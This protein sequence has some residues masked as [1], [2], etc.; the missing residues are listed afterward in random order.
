MRRVFGSALALAL[1]GCATAQFHSV[2]EINSVG[3]ECGVALG[4]LFQDESEKRLLFLMRP[5]ATREQRACIAK[6]ARANHLKP[7]FVNMSF[8]S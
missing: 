3:R 1:S 7:V 8:D 4:E 5:G 2:D 6:W